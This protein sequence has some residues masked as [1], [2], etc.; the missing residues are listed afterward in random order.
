MEA[1]KQEKRYTYTDY[2]SWPDDVRVELIEGVPY[3]LAAP[4][5]RH[6]GI[7]R[8]LLRQLAN[9]L[10]GKPCEV[11]ETIGV[12]LNADAGDDSVFEP[13]ISIVCDS[14]KL[15]DG[16]TCKGAPDL[17]VEILSP[18]TA[19]RDC[20]IKLPKYLE[21]GVRECWIVDPDNETVFVYT[22]NGEPYPVVYDN[23]GAVPVGVLDGCVVELGDV[24]AG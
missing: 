9:F 23:G 6:Q 20:L 10:I 5:I 2:L 19:G 21:A 13:D 18:S 4:S 1:L 3:A 11:Y 12:R 14:A 8:E 17:V 22:Q 7:S 15:S 24:F 16:R